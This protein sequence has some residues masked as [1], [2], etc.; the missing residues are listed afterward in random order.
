MCDNHSL[1]RRFFEV[2]VVTSV[3]YFVVEQWFSLRNCDSLLHTGKCQRRIYQA[4]GQSGTIESPGYPKDYSP[5]QTCIWR[6]S[7][8]TGYRIHIHF[9]PRF[10]VTRT[11]ACKDEYV[12]V[13][14]RRQR[15][16]DFNVV[17]NSKDSVVF[18]GNQ[19]P[20]NVS[21]P[22][23]EMWVRFKSRS[24]GRKGFRA[25]YG[26]EGKSFTHCSFVHSQ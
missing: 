24:G 10:D 7:V 5:L 9:D 3:C 26:A 14:T 13:S 23:N 2:M 15:F 21:S 19:K 17:R 6:I 11:A 25:W 4:T 1:S 16:S 22:S 12:L 18:C 8:N 20:S